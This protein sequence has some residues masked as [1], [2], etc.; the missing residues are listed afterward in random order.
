MNEQFVEDVYNTIQ[1]VLIPQAQVQGERIFLRRG[2]SV[3][4]MTW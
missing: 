4:D 2:R 1:G 3:R